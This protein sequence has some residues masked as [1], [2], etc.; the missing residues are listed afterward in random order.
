M[1]KMCLKSRR[2]PCQRRASWL[3]KHH[4]QR[5]LVYKGGRAGSSLCCSPKAFLLESPCKVL[6]NWQN[7]RDVK[8]CQRSQCASQDYCNYKPSV[9]FF[10]PA[11]R[12]YST[13]SSTSLLRPFPPSILSPTHSQV[14]LLQ[15]V[16]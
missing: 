5:T 15:A 6:V 16:Y 7:S 14:F 10:R 13:I 11:F 9:H 8:S 1:L 12:W 4:S 3:M 2:N